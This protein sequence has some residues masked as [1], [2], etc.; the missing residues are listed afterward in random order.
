MVHHA[1]PDKAIDIDENVI[2]ASLGDQ[3][4]GVSPHH[5]EDI[6]EHNQDMADHA[7]GDDSEI[8]QAT[9]HGAKREKVFGLFKDG[10]RGAVKTIAAADKLRAKVGVE[11]SKLRAGVVPSSRDATGFVG[12][13]Q[14]SARYEGRR[15]FIHVNSDDEEPWVAFN[16]NAVNEHGDLRTVWKIK[17]DDIV[18]LRKH[19]GHGMLAKLATGWA[20]NGPIYDS[21]RIVDTDENEWVVT[22]LP[23]RDALFNRLCAIGTRARW[24]VW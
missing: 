19:T 12:P 11:S 2:G 6:A 22:A 15:G 23:Y 8:T 20:T 16:R 5:L 14:F 17:I 1:P 7:G 18:Q 10:A 24:E 13:V 9:G 4:L 21:V 3:P